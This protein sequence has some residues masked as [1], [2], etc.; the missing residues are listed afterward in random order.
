MGL[1]DSE[2]LLLAHARSSFPEG[3][4]TATGSAKLSHYIGR[5]AGTL[6]ELII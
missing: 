5:L 4:M 3:K 1:V 6:Q 2:L